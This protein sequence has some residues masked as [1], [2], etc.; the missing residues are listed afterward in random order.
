MGESVTD[1][2]LTSRERERGT[3]FWQMKGEDDITIVLGVLE[4]VITV[5]HQANEDMF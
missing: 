4:K 5:H 1:L 2:W 3:V